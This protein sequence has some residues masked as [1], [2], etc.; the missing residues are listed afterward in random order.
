M[1]VALTG[2]DGFTG[3]YVAAELER[4]GVDWVE[5]GADLTEPESLAEAVR[6]IRFDC[7]IHLAGVAFAGGPDWRPFY[8]V[9]QIGTLSL[10]EAVARVEP[11]ARCILASSA[12][13]YGPQASG[14]LSEALPSAP[15]GHYAISKYAMELGAQRWAADLDITVVRPFNYTGRGQ[16]ARYLVP[17]IVDHFRRRADVIELGNLSIKRDFG[18]VR[19]VAAAYCDLASSPAAPPLLNLG[20]GRLQ[21]IGDLI[22][23]LEALTAHSMPVRVNPAFVR[24]DDVPELGADITLLNASLPA[25]SPIPI[26]ETLAWMLAEERD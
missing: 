1:R 6:S 18:D 16:E 15:A 12:Q 23:T 25:W 3:R 7:L 26:E 20:T 4:R 19:A 9:N 24:S 5:L 10:L 13:V 22:A 14:L 17:K 2:A 11:G 8:D 21:T